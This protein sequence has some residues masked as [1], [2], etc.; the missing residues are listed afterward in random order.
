VDQ[1]DKQTA[2]NQH[3]KD[4]HKE[5]S[6]ISTVSLPQFRRID[7]LRHNKSFSGLQWQKLAT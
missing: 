1:K 6:L 4:K 7:S 3:R 5:A 2:D